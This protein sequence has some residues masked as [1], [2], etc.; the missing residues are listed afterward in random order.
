MHRKPLTAI[1]VAASVLIATVGMA[2]TLGQFDPDGKPPTKG[3]VAVQAFRWLRDNAP[4]AIAGCDKNT[5]QYGDLG[6]G[7]SVEVQTGSDQLPCFCRVLQRMAGP[8][9]HSDNNG[10]NRNQC[11]FPPVR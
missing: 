4:D 1:L 10:D 9:S 3:F 7:G 2:A 5:D 6:P 11:G 8:G